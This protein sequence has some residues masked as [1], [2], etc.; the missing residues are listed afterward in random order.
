MK[1]TSSY[2]F[3]EKIKEKGEIRSENFREKMKI[4]IVFTFGAYSYIILKRDNN[5]G[6]FIDGLGN[7]VANVIKLPLTYVSHP[8]D[9]FEKIR[10][11]S[12]N[13]STL[14]DDMKE[15]FEEDVETNGKAYAI[16]NS[17]RMATSNIAEDVNNQHIS[18]E[19]NN[20]VQQTIDGFNK[21]VGNLVNGTFDFLANPIK[22]SKEIIHQIKNTENIVKETKETSE[23]SGVMYTVGNLAANLLPFLVPGPRVL[24]HS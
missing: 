8:I 22:V 21:G 23:K 2:F 17:V 3:R 5:V 6:K 14:L 18:K 9:S 1:R 20:V 11:Q 10:E 15:K 19:N 16:G 13:P 12:L 24:P 4:S 7:S